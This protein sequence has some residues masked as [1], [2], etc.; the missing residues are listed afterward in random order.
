MDP[1]VRLS[2]G[3]YRQEK[4][5]KPLKELLTQGLG[6]QVKW[7]LGAAFNYKGRNSP[8]VKCPCAQRK[9]ITQKHILECDYWHEIIKKAVSESL[10]RS[11]VT[12][13]ECINALEA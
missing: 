4:Q 7:Y 12:I 2:S 6:H 8:T 5:Q 3:Y 11:G 1:P 9:D 13:L 10:R